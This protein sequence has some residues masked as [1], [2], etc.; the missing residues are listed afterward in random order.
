MECVQKWMNHQGLRWNV[1]CVANEG[2]RKRLNLYKRGFKI[3][4]LDFLFFCGFFQ[5][6][7]ASGVSLVSRGMG[8]QL[9]I[10]KHGQKGSSFGEARSPPRLLLCYVFNPIYIVVIRKPIDFFVFCGFFWKPNA[11]G[12]TLGSREQGYE[13]NILKNRQKDAHFGARSPLP[14]LLRYV[15]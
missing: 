14:L 10:L 11:F 9:N 15:L 13:P 5:K 12:V 4:E 3:Y 2:L 1:H 8:Y 6:P 7:K